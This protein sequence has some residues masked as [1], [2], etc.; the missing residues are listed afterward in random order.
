MQEH[1]PDIAFDAFDA[2]IFVAFSGDRRAIVPLSDLGSPADVGPSFDRF[3]AAGLAE[4]VACDGFHAATLTPFAAARLG[5]SL[6]ETAHGYRWAR[7]PS[8]L[9]LRP[10]PRRRETVDLDS[11]PDPRAIAPDEII[12]ARETF[13]AVCG[14]VFD[15]LD[16][17]PRPWV[18]L[19]G[20]RPWSGEGDAEHVP[21]D[22]PAC[23]NRRLRPTVYCL[24]C[25]RW[26]LDDLRTRLLTSLR[27]RVRA[28]KS[29]RRQPRF[30]PV[31]ATA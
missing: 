9:P 31:G 8:D 5:L 2:A 28:A 15:R 6:V 20:C 3:V 11:L 17:L 29:K 14:D 13:G 7:V 24:Y 26:G 23:R 25:D 1:F 30:V 22:C 19:T 4:I 18:L 21:A 12:E 27:V 10:R 16:R